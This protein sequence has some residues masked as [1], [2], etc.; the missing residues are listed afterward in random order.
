VDVWRAI[1]FL[2]RHNFVHGD[3]KASNVAR[4]TTGRLFL[5]DWGW[6]S[7]L[8]T[9]EAVK[10]QLELMAQYKDYQIPQYG[11]REDGIWSPVIWSRGVPAMKALDWDRMRDVLLF[12]DLFSAAYLTQKAIRKMRISVPRLEQL[13]K[14]C[15][16]RPTELFDS[17]PAAWAAYEARVIRAL[18]AGN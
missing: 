13:L 3:L 11:G 6:S 16:D 7:D 2:R 9:P 1:A 10:E 5:T 4:R 14:E 18:N 12:N 17:G 8:N 15:I